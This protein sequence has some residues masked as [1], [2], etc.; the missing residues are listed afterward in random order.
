MIPGS[1]RSDA[2]SWLGREAVRSE[3]LWDR[4]A[5]EVPHVAL[6]NEPGDVVVFDHNIMHAS[7]GGG[8]ARRMFT[9]NISRR[10][11]SS[12]ELADLRSYINAHARLF[13]DHMHSEL[14]R[15]G[16]PAGRTRQ[17]VQV[18]ELEGD[19]P[20]LHAELRQAGAPMACG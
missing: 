15:T 7:V 5:A 6:S 16:G 10:T 18:L 14:M 20:A 1:H 12:E 11:T 19:L 13:I 8:A 3:E 2:V 4:S 9:L 17:L